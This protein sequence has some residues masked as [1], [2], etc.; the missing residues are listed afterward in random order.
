MHDN[1]PTY[2]YSLIDPPIGSAECTRRAEESMPL[3]SGEVNAKKK[4]QLVKNKSIF[5]CLIDIAP[6]TSI[7]KSQIIDDD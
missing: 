7:Q 1:K 5:R 4:S 6:T 2:I 3:A